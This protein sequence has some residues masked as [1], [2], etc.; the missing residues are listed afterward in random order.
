MKLLFLAL[1]VAV[2]PLT[3]L[4]QSSSQENAAA[5]ASQWARL[6]G[7]SDGDDCGARANARRPVSPSQHH[8]VFG[9]RTGE[10]PDAQNLARASIV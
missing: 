7:N 1:F 9:T 3:V 10:G 6:A 8:R 5:A 4:G 2:C